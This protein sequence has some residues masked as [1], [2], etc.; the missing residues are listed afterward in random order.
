MNFL[1]L[2]K[3]RYSVRK[4]KDQKVEVEKLEMILEAGRVAPTG[5]NK[6]PQHLI[7]VQEEEGLKKLGKAANTFGAPLAILVCT[8][9]EQAWTRPFDG[10]NLSH[11]DATIVTDHMMMQA[12]D[13]NLGTVWVCYFDPKIIKEEYNLPDNLEPINILIVGY[14]EG[15]PAAADRHSTM[16]KPLSTTVSYEKL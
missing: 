9:K 5:A 7:V 12:T 4:Y 15:E 11:I 14:A 2:A 6:Q 8:N 16:R 10:F 13:L 3:K 1:D